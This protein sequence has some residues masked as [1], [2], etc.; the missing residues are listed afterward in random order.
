MTIAA[1]IHLAGLLNVLG[2]VCRVEHRQAART[3]PHGRLV[4]LALR[5]AA[6]PGEINAHDARAE[7]MNTIWPDGFQTARSFSSLR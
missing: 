7:E 4:G 1:L 3:D 6:I 5:A 2:D